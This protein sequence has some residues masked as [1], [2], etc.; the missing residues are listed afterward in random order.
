M[1][2]VFLVD[3]SFLFMARTYLLN[4]WWRLHDDGPVLVVPYNL[5][6]EH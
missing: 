6:S 5:L 1:I 3:F 4:I 2:I